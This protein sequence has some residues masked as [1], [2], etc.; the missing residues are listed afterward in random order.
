[1][2]NGSLSVKAL[3]VVMKTPMAWG[4]FGINYATL[5]VEPFPFMIISGAASQTGEMC[6]IAGNTVSSEPCLDATAAGDAREVFKFDGRQIQ[7]VASK[8]CIATDSASRAVGLQECASAAQA[9]DGRSDWAL[10]S[11]SQLKMMNFGNYCLSLDG[12][13]AHVEDC[14]DAS[15]RGDSADRYLFLAVQDIDADAA[16]GVRSEASLLTAAASRQS[17]LLV[18]LQK[19]LPVLESC[20]P[21]FTGNISRW[22]DVLSLSRLGARTEIAHSNDPA[23]I[24]IGRIYSVIGADMENAINLIRESST[25]ALAAEH[26][27]AG[28]VS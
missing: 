11:T 8:K 27:L 23:L 20:K 15:L 16:S 10:S 25:T 26:K 19:L 9:R 2:F 12:G 13:A 6:L 18:G 17:K 22:R 21:S 3:T 14:N 24:A 5:L 7:H 28:L 4:Y 1:M